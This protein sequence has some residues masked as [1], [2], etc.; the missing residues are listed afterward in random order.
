[1]AEDYEGLVGCPA[2]D[3]NFPSGIGR[4]SD[5]SLR[6]FHTRLIELEAAEG[7]H[8]G[9]IKAVDKELKN[10]GTVSEE[11]RAIEVV[12]ADIRAAEEQFADGMPYELDRIEKQIRFFQEQAGSAL[13]EMGKCLIRIK[14]HEAHGRFMQV[15]ETAG[16]T[17]RS[18]AYAMAAARRF[19]NVPTLAHLESS[20]MIA[21]TVLDDDEIDTLEKGGN[22]AGMTLD[23]I[24]RMS[25][26][27]L[28]ENLRKEREKVK[29]EKEGRKKDR[30]TQDAAIAQKEMKINELDQQLRYQQPS[31]KEQR[32]VAALFALAAPYS[33]ALADV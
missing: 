25:V 11:S 30:E 18:A 13:L 10:R 29:T 14:A 20:K 1:M 23:D 26:R 15:L 19:A 12:A 24:E 22:I 27:E 16:M 21:L 4:L 32:A 5:E 3:V 6:A 28:R 31:T 8:K 2:T 9:R 17:Y 33:F 7:G